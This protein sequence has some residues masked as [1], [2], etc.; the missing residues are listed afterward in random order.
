MRGIKYYF[1]TRFSWSSVIPY[2]LLLIL[3]V[4]ITSI[5]P[6]CFSLYYLNS[7]SG[8]ALPLIFLA[9]G[10]TF[11]L[12]S[13]GMDLSV[14]G[15]MSLV[16]C[17]MATVSENNLP[18][19]IA[20]C[21]G[22]AVLVG[23]I[24]GLIIYKF[25]LQPFV[26]TLGTWSTLNGVAVAILRTDGGVINEGFTKFMNGKVGPFSTAFFLIVGILIIWFIVR[27]TPLVYSICAIGSNEKAAYCNGVNLFK[28]KI[29]TYIIS[30]VCAA[31]GGLAYCGL[32][33]TGSPTVGE[34]NILMSAAAAVIGGTSLAGGKGGLV[35]TIVGVFILKII[36]DLLVFAGVSSYYTTLFQ[37]LLLILSVALGS[38]VLMIK[39]RGGPED[40]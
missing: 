35:G 9:A 17:I 30:S 1:K 33:K 38:I 22:A 23:F 2:A 37:G 16:T 7:K 10:Q 21:L 27:N 36:S 11:V 32:M 26:A 29:S 12:I 5:Q 4:V 28:V 34:P 31:L 14:G 20:I 8:I 13:M 3:V 15:V 18:L 24:N 40:D 39:R 25:K 6:R 19:A